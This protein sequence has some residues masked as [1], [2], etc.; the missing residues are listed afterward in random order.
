MI[1]ASGNHR[2][3]ITSP[4]HTA[5]P[6]RVE[7]ASIYIASKVRTGLTPA[8]NALGLI[9]ILVTVL[10][11]V[12]YEIMRRREQARER[13]ALRRSEQA[14][15]QE[16]QPGIVAPATLHT[17]AVERPPRVPGRDHQLDDAL[18]PGDQHEHREQDDRERHPV[19]RQRHQAAHFSSTYSLATPGPRANS[20][21]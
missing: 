3:R 18:D 2:K 1:S 5:S 20:T 14:G 16:H 6:I 21:P 8:V 15:M 17:A 12:G 11:A 7:R 13:E 4:V 19:S 10:G 9:L